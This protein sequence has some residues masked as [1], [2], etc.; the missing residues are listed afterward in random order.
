MTRK[1]KRSPK[2]AVGPSPTG[3]WRNKLHPLFIKAA[4]LNRRVVML[5]RSNV[6][7][8]RQE[9]ARLNA[10]NMP[11]LLREADSLYDLMKP[12]GQIRHLGL[13]KAFGIENLPPGTVISHEEY[14]CRFLCWF[15]FGKTI[16]TL[17]REYESRERKA[18]KQMNKLRLEL[19]LWRIGEV[20]PNKLK[21]KTD[22]DHFTL[23]NGGLDLGI[24][25]LTQSE[26]ADCFDELCPC[27]KQH[28]PENLGKLRAR[29]LKEFPPT[30]A[31]DADCSAPLTKPDRMKAR[32]R[33]RTPK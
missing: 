13:L 19:D 20:N 17:T 11:N 30:S 8:E 4:E 29:I 31:S 28:F 25:N 1:S 21:F 2:L 33:Q 18:V 23:M 27:A 10:K 9:A 14:I 6:P 3:T 32:K 7:E 16:E 12:A 5:S 22:L 26:L 15:R 24:E